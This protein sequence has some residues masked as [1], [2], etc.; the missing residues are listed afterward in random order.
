MIRGQLLYG[1]EVILKPIL[2]FILSQLKGILSGN[3]SPP[4]EKEGVGGIYITH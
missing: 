3:Y 4:F 2:G 1:I